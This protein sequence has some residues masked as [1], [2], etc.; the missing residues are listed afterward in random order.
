MSMDTPLPEMDGDDHGANSHD[1]LLSY[2]RGE[3]DVEQM[4]KLAQRLA[5]SPAL[6][7]ELAWL[8]ATAQAVQDDYVNSTADAAFARLESALGGTHAG[9]TTSDNAPNPTSLS[10]NRASASSRRREPSLFERLQAWLRSHAPALQPI[11][12]TLI[13]AQA[14][15]LGY[16]INGQNRDHVTTEA[17]AATRGATGSCLD[18]WVTPTPDATVKGLRDWLLQYG[19][20]IVAGPD[21]QGRL[22]ITLPDVESRVAFIHDPAR[23][24]L[25]QSIDDAVQCGDRAAAATSA[26]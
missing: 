18:V 21:A 15:V 23:S 8:R 14:G 1:A 4:R 17:P 25:T 20:S 26:P 5:A 7:E 2:L 3:L 19:G 13:V 6:R 22:R 12:L 9:R 16:F 10:P 11:L 24:R